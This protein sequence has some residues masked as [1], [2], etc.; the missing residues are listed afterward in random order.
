MLD[1]DLSILGSPPEEYEKFEKGV[2]EEY[3]RVPDISFSPQQEE[4]FAVVLGPITNLLFTVF[5]RAPG[6]SSEGKPHKSDQ[7]ALT[8]VFWD[9]SP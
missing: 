5:F 7:F 8:S 1:I 6:S 2:R 3:R 4:D 9:L